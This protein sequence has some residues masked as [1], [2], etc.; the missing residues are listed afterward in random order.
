[1]QEDRDPVLLIHGGAGAIADEILSDYRAGLQAA[2]DAGWER[3]AG[4]G[5]SVDA[6]E[7]AITV[8]EDSG[9]FD[10]GCG[11][12]L[13]SD[14]RV[15][16]DAMLMDGASLDA[17]GIGA[18]ETVRNPIRVARAVMEASEQVY[19]AGHGAERFA[20][21]HGFEPIDN[22]D[23]VTP[24]ER[25]RFLEAREA[26]SP[27]GHDTV[28][29][30]ALDR[31]GNLASG[32]STGGIRHKP[33]GRIGDSSMI[34]SGCY[35]DNDSAAVS[36]TGEGEAIMRLVLGKW[37]ADQVAGGRHPQAAA[38]AAIERLGTRLGGHGGLILLDRSGR[39]GVAFNARRMAWGARTS[40]ASQ[41]SVDEG[42]TETRRPSLLG[43]NDATTG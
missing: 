38:D 9:T 32:T 11:S 14:G 3:L 41:V 27:G 29:A 33:V 28:G 2:L 4:G 13:N 1:M 40:R 10:A 7:V 37:A 16:L 34:G 6:V 5:S 23:L 22:A 43:S 12:V 39:R 21:E 42:D 17:G 31:R 15:Q 19:F 35:A 25:R 26:A 18:V 30:V 24:R 20:V 8:M 36:C